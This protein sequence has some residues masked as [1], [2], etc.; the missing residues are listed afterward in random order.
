MACLYFQFSVWLLARKLLCDGDDDLR[1]GNLEMAGVFD[2]G[3][4]RDLR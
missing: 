3:R 1:H 2:L 4:A